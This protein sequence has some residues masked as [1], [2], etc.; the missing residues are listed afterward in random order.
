MAY[1]RFRIWERILWLK[2]RDKI[3]ECR[4]PVFHMT[5][6][7][8]TRTASGKA[9]GCEVVGGSLGLHLCLN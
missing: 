3:S 5:A 2:C 7:G 8:A 9:A 4:R 1:S 6:C